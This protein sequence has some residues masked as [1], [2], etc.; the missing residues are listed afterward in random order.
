MKE[1]VLVVSPTCPTCEVVK[2]YL[3]ENGVLQ[4]YSVVDVSTPD[5]ME[6]AKRLGITG[7][8]EC[9]II[10]GEGQQKTVRVCSKEEW[11]RLLEGQ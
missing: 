3:R 11:A 7:V 6:F 1:K 10:E 2:K 8:P 5:G 9:A 4:N